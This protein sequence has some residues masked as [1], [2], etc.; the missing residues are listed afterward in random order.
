MKVGL[1]P[2]S[3]SDKN[4]PALAKKNK[5]DARPISPSLTPSLIAEVP[6]SLMTLP[7]GMKNAHNQDAHEKYDAPW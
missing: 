2:Q 6:A 7:A 4:R 5:L 3:P 1:R